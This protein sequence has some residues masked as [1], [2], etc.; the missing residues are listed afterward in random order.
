MRISQTR[1]RTKKAQA[2]AWAF[3]LIA[4]SGIFFT[5]CEHMLL[6][7]A[8][9]SNPPIVEELNRQEKR[10]MVSQ[11]LR[12]GDR[13]FEEKN[14]NLANATYE[15]IFLLEANHL[16]A[17][18]RIDRLKKH[19]MQEGKSETEL[20]TRVYDREIENRVETYLKQ[21]KQLIAEQKL[22][23]ARFTLQKLLLINPL[24]EEARELYNDLDQPGRDGTL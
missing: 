10:T 24:N 5:V 21:A 20:V 12:E 15:S 16:E 7:V 23:Q 22:N 3:L 8:V 17:S 19:M 11:L 2:C 13:Y 18:Q 4:W 6:S 9:A 1:S 14:Y